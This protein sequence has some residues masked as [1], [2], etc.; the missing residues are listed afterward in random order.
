MRKKDDRDEGTSECTRPHDISHTAR[1]T[2]YRH[3]NGNIRETS[4]IGR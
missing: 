3:I 1:R 4:I 2:N